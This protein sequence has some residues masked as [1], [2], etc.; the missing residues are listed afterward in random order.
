MEIGKIVAH[1]FGEY[2]H[3]AQVLASKIQ[4]EEPQEKEDKI[5]SLNRELASLKM[6]NAKLF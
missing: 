1:S 5:L 3:I 6:E 2:I 4:K